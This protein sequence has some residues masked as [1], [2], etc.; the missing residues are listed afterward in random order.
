MVTAVVGAVSSPTLATRQVVSRKAI[1]GV[2]GSDTLSRMFAA[3][4][5][6]TAHFTTAW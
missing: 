1:S 5:N 3:A 6:V 4:V 2:S